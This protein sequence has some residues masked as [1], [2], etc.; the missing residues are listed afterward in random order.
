MATLNR[1]FEQR[2]LS[3]EREGGKATQWGGRQAFA[4]LLVAVTVVA[5]LLLIALRQ[6]SQALAISSTI[7]VRATI[8]VGGAPQGI[9]VNPNTDRIYVAAVLP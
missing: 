2:K 4:K 5:V 1:L 8:P 9:A 3:G 7:T 6:E